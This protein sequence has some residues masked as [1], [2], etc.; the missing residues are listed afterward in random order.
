MCLTASARA[1]LGASTQTPF[2][3]VA[4]LLAGAV[5]QDVPTAQAQGALPLGTSPR[6]RTGLSQNT[7]RDFLRPDAWSKEVATRV[8]AEASAYATGCW[9]RMDMTVR[10]PFCT[11]DGSAHEGRR[12]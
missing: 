5:A 6:L 2:E 3:V 1:R 10:L 9:H 8:L 4:A 7:R 12:L 11:A